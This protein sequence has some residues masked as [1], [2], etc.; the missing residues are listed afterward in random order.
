MK[1][2]GTGTLQDG[3]SYVRSGATGRRRPA[4]RHLEELHCGQII[5]IIDRLAG[6]MVEIVSLC[7][8]SL[9]D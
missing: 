1:Q 9:C 4:N 3:C 5:I 6:W 8:F 7:V 2:A